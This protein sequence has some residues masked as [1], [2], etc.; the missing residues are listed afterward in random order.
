MSKEKMIH[1][2]VEVWGD[3]EIKEHWIWPTF[4]TFKMW[5]CRALNTYVINKKPGD[6]E[7]R[8]Y[9][10]IWKEPQIGLFPVKTKKEVKGSSEKW[11]PLDNLPPPYLVSMPA[12]AQAPTPPSAPP[13]L[14][15]QPVQAQASSRKV[16]ATLPAQAA[17]ALPLLATSAVPLLPSPPSPPLIDL[18]PPPVSALQPQQIPG[19]PYT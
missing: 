3:K 19:P 17:A 15:L 18:Q 7:E 5:A 1:Y 6:W 9:T 13:D 14:M 8:Q 2:C 4:G 12:Q 11:E 10:E 16:L